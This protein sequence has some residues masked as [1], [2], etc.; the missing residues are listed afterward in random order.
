MET[1]QLDTKKIA[2]L[3]YQRAVRLIV[4]AEEF[5]SLACGELC[6][7]S[8]AAEQWKEVGK[9]YDKVQ[10]LRRTVD[11]AYI[12]NIDLDSDEKARLRRITAEQ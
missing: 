4:K 5:L 6:P 8:G 7:L 2:Q 11:Y 3:K 10:E 1:E 12:G 9:M